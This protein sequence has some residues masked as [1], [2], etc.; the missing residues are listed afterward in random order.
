MCC[1]GIF[2]N[3]PEKNALISVPNIFARATSSDTLMFIRFVSNFAYVLFVM[4]MPIR[5]NFAMTCS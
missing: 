2:Y 5:F 4:G 1:A 3:N